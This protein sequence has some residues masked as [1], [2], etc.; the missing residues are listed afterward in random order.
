VAVAVVDVQVN[1]Q[2]AVRNLQQVNTAS[3]ASAAGINVLKSALG[4]LLAAFTAVNAIKFTVVKT[5]ELE[6]QTRSLQTLTGSVEK[7]KQIIQE[8]QRLGAA[9]PFTST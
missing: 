6:T 3:R 1:S 5:A 9:T 4:P 8:L 2:Q 7:A